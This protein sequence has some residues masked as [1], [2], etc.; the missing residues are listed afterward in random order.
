MRNYLRTFANGEAARQ[1]LVMSLV[2][3]VNTVID[4]GLVNLFRFGFGWEQYLSVSLA[5]ILASVVSYVLNRRFTF[6][7]AASGVNASE[8][9]GFIA[10]N[11]VALLVTNAVVWVADA[12]VG[13]LDAL[14]LNVAKLVATAIILVPK[15]AAL[16]DI[17]F[18]KALAAHKA[19]GDGPE[20]PGTGERGEGA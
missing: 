16:R 5:F 9:A 1:F 13:P 6:G 4:F 15:F 10:L 17:V 20:G 19:Q 12:W 3:V 8:G 14:E 7:M 2:G 11:V 18:R